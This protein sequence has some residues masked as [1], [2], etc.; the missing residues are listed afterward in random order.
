MN[1]IALLAELEVSFGLYK[2]IRGN[3]AH[4]Q[5]WRPR[6]RRRVQTLLAR[7]RSVGLAKDPKVL[8]VDLKFSVLSSRS[9]P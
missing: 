6:Y 5:E 7:V 1:K 8:D 4:A 3:D 2:G 9:S